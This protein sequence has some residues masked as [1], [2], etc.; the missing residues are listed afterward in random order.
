[1]LAQAE[2][3]LALLEQRYADAIDAVRRS[4]IGPQ[5]KTSAVRIAKVF[6]KAGQADSALHY[7]ERYVNSTSIDL[8]IWSEAQ[9]L[10]LARRR[11]AQL[12]EDRRDYTKAYEMYSAFAH[13]WRNADPELQPIVQAARARMTALEKLR[14]Q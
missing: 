2:T 14:A 8:T 11:L 4:D 9:D 13:Q 6:D 3:F 5:I 10:A 12:Y 7:Y 1:M